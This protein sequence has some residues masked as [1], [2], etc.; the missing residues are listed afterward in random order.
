MSSPVKQVGVIGAGIMASGMAIN[1][2][3]NGHKV[4]V[5]NRTKQNLEPLIKAGCVVLDSPKMVAAASDL[6]VECVSDDEAS[7]AVWLGKQGILSG[8]NKQKVLVTCASLSLDWVDELAAECVS[9]GLQFLDMP[10]TG[11]RSGAESG[12]LILVVGGDAAVL[13]SIKE[14]LSAISSKIC[15]FGAQGTGM[16]FKLMLNTLSAIH[17]NAA[18]QAVAIAKKA[19]IDESV[20]FEAIFDGDMGPASPATNLLRAAKDMPKDRINFAVK[21]IEKDLRYAKHMAQK[22]DSKFDLLNDTQADYV[23]V[24]KQGSTT[25]DWTVIAKFFESNA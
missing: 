2:A 5:W 25:A 7:R 10:I 22:Y 9:R 3:K 11:G 16:R 18:A 24:I 13:A 23:N 4:F 21:W 17:V 20:F 6:V 19:G 1:F 12:N 15:H 14:D 8:A